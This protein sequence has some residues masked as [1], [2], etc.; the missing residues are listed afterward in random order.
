MSKPMLPLFWLF[1]RAVTP[2]TYLAGCR[3]SVLEAVEG[4]AVAEAQ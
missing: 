4:N 2:R 3:A 1:N